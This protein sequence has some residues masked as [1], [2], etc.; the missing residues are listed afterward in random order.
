[1][2]KD[3]YIDFFCEFIIT[4]KEV[5]IGTITRLINIKP[6]RSFEKGETKVSQH[7]GS[8]ITR[9]HNLWAIS[10]KNIVTEKGLAFHIDHLKFILSEKMDLLESLKNQPN[11]EMVF[12][13][14]I[15]T[16]DAGIGFDITDNDLAFIRKIANTTHFS[17]VTN[18]EK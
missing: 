1:M 4:S 9:P 15:E 5:E 6:S 10:T 8:T 17:I 12:W 18:K 7:S 11:L 2:Q 14:W 3:Y 16:D 13:I